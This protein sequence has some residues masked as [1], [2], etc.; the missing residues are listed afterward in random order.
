MVTYNDKPDSNKPEF[1]R[2]TDDS[3]D[4]VIISGIDSKK[5]TIHITVD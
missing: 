3:F 4:E 2:D 1:F 5:E